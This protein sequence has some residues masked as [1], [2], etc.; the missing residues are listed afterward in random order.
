MALLAI[1]ERAKDIRT[2][3]WR[4]VGLDDDAQCW[5][6]VGSLRENGYGQ[7]NIDQYPYKV[8]RISYALWNGALPQGRF[9]VQHHC[10][11]PQCVNPAHLYAGTQSD[12]MRDEYRRGRRKHSNRARG[13]NVHTAKL[14]DDLVRE[15][16]RLHE[17]GL[18]FGKT[19]K[20]FH[21]TRPT[22]TR[23]IK[24]L[25]WPHVSAP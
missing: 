22:I 18:S 4:Y 13:V 1:P 5:N 8:H 20:L 10:D 3:F 15:A 14:T 7:L 24:G 16:R 9:Q 12:N 25:T 11:N 2:R 6:W 23:A 17:Q 21:V 19:A